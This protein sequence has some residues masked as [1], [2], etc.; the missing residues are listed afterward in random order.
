M[1]S[2]NNPDLNAAFRDLRKQ[3]FIAKQNFLC[4]QGC[5]WSQIHRDHPGLAD[6]ANVIFYHK[7]DTDAAK[8][9]GELWL[10]WSGNGEMI[11][12][13][14]RRHGFTVD[15]D[16]QPNT[17]IKIILPEYIKNPVRQSQRL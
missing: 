15:W 16:G 17:R 4:C 11:C 8:E 3:G 10:A 5:A 14:L 1:S 9:D 6:D 12:S 13:T 2:L 7:Q